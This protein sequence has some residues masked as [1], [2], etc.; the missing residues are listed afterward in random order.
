MYTKIRQRESRTDWHIK[1]A[2]GDKR[3]ELRE[4]RGVFLFVALRERRADGP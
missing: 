3:G 1:V 2:R 4:H